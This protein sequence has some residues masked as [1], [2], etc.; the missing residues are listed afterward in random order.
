M[1]EKVKELRGLIYSKYNSEAEMA[2]IMGWTRQKVNKITNGT[3]EPNVDELNA[4]AK[5]LDKTVG[6]VAQIFLRNKSPNEQQ[7]NF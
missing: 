6:D 1:T 2:K 7:K 5:A 3:K 4:F